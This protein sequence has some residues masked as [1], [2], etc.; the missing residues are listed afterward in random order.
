MR[1]GHEGLMSMR[2][3]GIIPTRA[4]SKGVPRKNLA[5]LRGR[6][7]IYYTIRA[8]Q[9]SRRLSRTVLS[10]EDQQIAAVGRRY[11]MDVPFLRP[12]GL[13]GDGAASV[14]V[15]VHG[16][17]TIEELEAQRYD[18]VVLLQP[19][20]PLRIA[21]DIDAAIGLLERSGATSVVSVTRL[22]E[23]HPVKVMTVKAGVLS[24]FLPEYWRETMR[25][26]E[27]PAVYRLNGAIY[28]VKRDVVINEKS[29][30]GKRALPYEMPPERSVNID[31]RMDL[32]VAETVLRLGRTREPS[33]A[34]G[35][36]T[37]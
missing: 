31:T 25:R 35:A 13:A 6:P 15:V 29:L 20:A 28:C 11:G 14:D 34:G 1:G 37:R 5:Q 30:W 2:V 21:R 10:T 26:Q 7:L 33:S 27:L 3:L 16:L 4:G 23:P 19:T 32:M 22:E 17:T 18:C 9:E 8:S 24:P 36:W 12:A